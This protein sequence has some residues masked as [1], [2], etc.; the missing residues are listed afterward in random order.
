MP[1]LM[2]AKTKTDATMQLKNTKKNKKKKEDNVGV[3]TQAICITINNDQADRYPVQQMRNY[4]LGQL[5]M[6]GP[7]C[8]LQK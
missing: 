4:C 8:K 3:S 6:N 7:D 5:Y 1:K 2:R